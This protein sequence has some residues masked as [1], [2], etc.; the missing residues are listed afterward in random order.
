LNSIKNKNNT[1][2][3]SITSSI[4]KNV[5]SEIKSE[6]NFQ[7]LLNDQIKYKPTSDQPTQTN[8]D[9]SV[10]QQPPIK[11]VHKPSSNESK[12]IAHKHE[13]LLRAGSNRSTNEHPVKSSLDNSISTLGII[14]TISATVFVTPALPIGDGLRLENYP[15]EN[16]P[17]T[18]SNNNIALS[19]RLD[20]L[21]TQEIPLTLSK[22]TNDTINENLS[23]PNEAAM[24][25]QANTINSLTT[26]QPST[27][28]STSKLPNNNI[29]WQHEVTQKI[30]WMSNGENHTA[31]L[32]VNSQELGPLKVVVHVNNAQADA[33][34]TSSNPQLRQALED[35]MSNLREMMKESGFQ[36]GQAIIHNGNEQKNERPTHLF[37]SQSSSV[38]SIIDQN[39]INHS[40]IRKS[41]SLINT[42]A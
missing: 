7:N 35:G 9:S 31:T 17:A 19:I 36:L 15:Q 38:N 14:P 39:N 28:T 37:E 20:P 23:S 42:F 1:Y 41:S 26:Y 27:S 11:E 8:E 24:P 32:V 10:K 16:K 21:A 12:K 18:A 5:V 6:S 29:S 34:F 2:E 13:K 33:N 30:I 4:N 25:D 3:L 22:N 40:S